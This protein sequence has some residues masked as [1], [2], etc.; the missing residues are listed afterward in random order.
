MVTRKLI[1][2]ALKILAM[3]LQISQFPDVFAIGDSS[4]FDPILSMKKYPPTAQIPEATLWPHDWIMSYKWEIGAH[5]QQYAKQYGM[6]KYE[7]SIKTTK[8]TIKNGEKQIV[9]TWTKHTIPQD[10]CILVFHGPPKPHETISGEA[11][12]E[13]L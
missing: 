8:T 6:T 11:P 9:E 2:S 1:L 4:I 3:M 12:P 13:T 10:L 7:R 5:D